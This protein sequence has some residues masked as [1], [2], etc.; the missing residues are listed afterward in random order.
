M[1]MIAMLVVTLCAA[2]EPTLCETR[3]VRLSEPQ[4]MCLAPAELVSVARP[5]WRIMRWRCET[6]GTL[7]QG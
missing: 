7:A 4:V 5:G 1:P 3:N 6:R 2:A